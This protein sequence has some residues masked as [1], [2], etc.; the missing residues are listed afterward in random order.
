MS[1]ERDVERLVEFLVTRRSIRRF[2]PD[3]VSLELVARLISVARYAPSARNRQPW[4]FI[5]VT[6][7]EVIDRFSKL[8]RWA[9]PLRGAPLCVVVASDASAAPVSFQVDGAN[10]AVYLMLA[11]HAHGLGSL[12]IQTLR[13]VGEIQQVLGLPEHL[14]PVAIIALGWPDDVPPPPPRKS[15]EE[16]AF[17]NKYG[18]P[19][20]TGR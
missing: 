8:H 6:D 2:R 4:A 20:T 3:P 10:A 18:E 9:A 19:L 5:V 11:A 13:N 16:L 7:R 15:L 17:L 14:V 12:W 1:S